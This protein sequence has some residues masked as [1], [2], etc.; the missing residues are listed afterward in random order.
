MNLRARLDAIR[1]DA[2]WI[3]H[4]YDTAQAEHAPGTTDREHLIARST[5]TAARDWNMGEMNN[6]D[7]IAGQDWGPL[8]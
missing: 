8:G 7:D 1:E 3:L 2:R 4:A 5:P 6:A